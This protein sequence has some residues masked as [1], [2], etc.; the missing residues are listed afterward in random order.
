[1][2]ISGL[3]IVMAEDVKGISQLN[4]PGIVLPVIASILSDT[5][6][7]LKWHGISSAQHSITSRPRRSLN[8]DFFQRICAQMAFI[9]SNYPYYESVFALLNSIHFSRVI[10]DPLDICGALKNLPRGHV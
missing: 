7:F 8:T 9:S 10:H 1:M 4:P 3:A 5:F 2:H 6:P